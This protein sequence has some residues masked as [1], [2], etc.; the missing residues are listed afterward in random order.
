MANCAFSSTSAAR[1]IK[2]PKSCYISCQHFHDKLVLAL[3]FFLY[4]MCPIYCTVLLFIVKVFFY[5]RCLGGTTGDRCQLSCNQDHCENN[6]SC[7]IENQTLKCRWVKA[8]SSLNAVV[9]RPSS[10][11]PILLFHPSYWYNKTGR[12]I[13]P[14]DKITNIGEV[15]RARN[16]VQKTVARMQYLIHV[17][18]ISRVLLSID[19]I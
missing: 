2:I 4:S 7:F 12:S 9:L 10:P 8:A 15:Y 18:R 5:P 1:V 16:N 6:G 17:I 14:N 13:W 19:Y 11:L 3:L